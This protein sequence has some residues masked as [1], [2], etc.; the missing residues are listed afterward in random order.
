[1]QPSTPD[2]GN[3]VPAQQW[4]AVRV[5]RSDNM[6]RE[7]VVTVV[8]GLMPFLAVASPMAFGQGVGGSSPTDTSHVLSPGFGMPEPPV[9]WQSVVGTISTPVG[10]ELDPTGPAW[11]QHFQTEG[12]VL[13]NPDRYIQITENLIVIGDTPWTGWHVE[14]TNPDFHWFDWGGA[15][16]MRSQQLSTVLSSQQT[17]STPHPASLMPRFQQLRRETRSSSPTTSGEPRPI[18][19]PTLSILSSTQYLNLQPSS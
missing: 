18:R 8:V 10:V 1:M 19:S 16:V 2:A 15:G 4:P 11:V 3:D 17:S 5:S 12:G 9:N 13:I 7:S 14:L 6:L